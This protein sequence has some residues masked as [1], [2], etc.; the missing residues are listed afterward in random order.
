[1]IYK[2]EFKYEYRCERERETEGGG[3]ENVLNKLW[4][5]PILFHQ[6]FSLCTVI[7]L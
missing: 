4:I 2:D 3:G 7:G 6:T 5:D 1:M